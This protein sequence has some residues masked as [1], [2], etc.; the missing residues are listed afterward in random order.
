MSE[1]A[2]TEIRRLH[3]K[4]LGAIK[5]ARALGEM[6]AEGKVPDAPSERAVGRELTKVRRLSEVELRRY[7][8]V[9]WP[10]SFGSPDLP[11]SAAAAILELTR[12]LRRP[13]LI[14]LAR[15]YWRTLQ[16]FP[17]ASVGTLHNIAAQLALAEGDDVKCRAIGAAA[18]A[19]E[20]GAIESLGPFDAD[21]PE[22]IERAI[23]RIETVLGA[24]TPWMRQAFR[25]VIDG[26]YKKGGQD[27]SQR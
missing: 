11:Y 3:R 15:W 9:T 4:G 19:G 7:D 21:R 25:E 6:Y 24:F 14:P 17:G 26:S 13:P 5:I 12:V 27:E 1:A 10:E 20:L 22:E 23:T 8:E 2:R 18:V 16:G